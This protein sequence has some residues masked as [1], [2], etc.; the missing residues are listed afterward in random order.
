MKYL[1]T[2]EEGLAF[3]AVVEQNL[4]TV[5]KGGGRGEMVEEGKGKGRG[6]WGQ[7]AFGSGDSRAWSGAVL[8][9]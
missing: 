6:N 4:F 1:D 9:H 5:L 7:G 2:I 3:E 8:H